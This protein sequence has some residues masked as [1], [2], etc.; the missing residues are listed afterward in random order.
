[1]IAE[2]MAGLTEESLT[3]KLR[4]TEHDFVERKRRSAKG[5]W[6]QTAVAFANSAPIG[7]PAILFVGA[8]DQG[9]PQ[10]NADK[11]ED[12][13]KSVSGILDQAYPAI[14]RYVV[15]LHLNDGSCLAVV[16][17]GSEVRPHF[18]GTSY[19]RDWPQTKEASE[20]QFELLIAQRLSKV[21]TI[22]ESKGKQV[23]LQTIKNRGTHLSQLGGTTATVE[24]CN[25]FF[26]T[27]RF[28]AV[29]SPVAFRSIPLQWI[30]LSRDHRRNQLMIVS[31]E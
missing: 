22:L 14:Y 16:I 6:L 19:I 24:D 21:R 2:I 17:P 13:M 10:Q 23:T 27:L 30:E 26:V 4:S 28:G 1:M 25:Q 31:E 9:V 8:N 7:W 29:G 12:P 3:L 11:L 18:A 20:E 15:P 5:D